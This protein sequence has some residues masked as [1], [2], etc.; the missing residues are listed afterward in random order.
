MYFSRLTLPT[1]RLCC[2]V[3]TPRVNPRIG[4]TAPTTWNNSYTWQYSADYADQLRQAGASALLCKECTLWVRIQLSKKSAAHP[5]C[6]CADSASTVMCGAMISLT[7]CIASKVDRQPDLDETMQFHDAEDMIQQL[8][9]ILSKAEDFPSIPA[10]R[11]DCHT[12]T[13]QPKKR[14]T[15]YVV[16][17]ANGQEHEALPSDISPSQSIQQIIQIQQKCPFHRKISEISILACPVPKTEH[18]ATENQQLYMKWIEKILNIDRRTTKDPR[19]YCAYCD[20]NNHPRFSCKHVYKHRDPKAKHRCTLCAGRHPP[21]LC[22]KAQ[23]NG[24]EAKPNWY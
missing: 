22:P 7:P 16:C 21:F 1:A 17:P 18:L 10:P 23:I 19:V 3:A 6:A 2:P 9:V 14:H 15:Q 11:K 20:M 24:G 8:N 5:N 12:M 4:H 13:F